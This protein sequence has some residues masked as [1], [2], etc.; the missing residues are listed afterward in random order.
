MGFGVATLIFMIDKSTIAWHPCVFL[1]PCGL[2]RL[3]LGSHARALAA[4]Q[5][6]F[7]LRRFDSDEHLAIGS[8]CHLLSCPA[9]FCENATAVWASVVEKMG[10]NDS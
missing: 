5:H 3:L 1:L 6:S 7:L 8:I 2:G 9:D 10:D 4:V